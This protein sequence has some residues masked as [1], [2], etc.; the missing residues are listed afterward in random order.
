MIYLLWSICRLTWHFQ[1]IEI[2][3]VKNEVQLIHSPFLW[4]S[5]TVESGCGHHQVTTL[6]VFLSSLI[7]SGMV[8]IV[9]AQ[10]YLEILFKIISVYKCKPTFANTILETPLDHCLQ[11]DGLLVKDQT[12]SDF[13][14]SLEPIVYKFSNSQAYSYNIHG[15]VLL[16]D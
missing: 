1:E 15:A 16:C 8:Q 9:Q 10:V 11:S 14:Q 7:Q 4:D 12:V 13:L 3:L 5:Q 6:S 2:T